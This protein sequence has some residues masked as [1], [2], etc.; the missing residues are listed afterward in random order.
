MAFTK[1]DIDR[2][3]DRIAV[4]EKRDFGQGCECADDI[5]MRDFEITDRAVFAA[6]LHHVFFGVFHLIT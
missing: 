3:A 6:Y 5:L 4:F 1:C 2:Y